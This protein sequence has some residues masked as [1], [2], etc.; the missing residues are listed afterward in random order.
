MSSRAWTGAEPLPERQ[1]WL[2]EAS[3]GTGKTFTIAGLVVRLVAEYGISIERILAITFTKAATA[4]LRDRVRK[5][6]VEALHV[7]RSPGSPASADPF[8]AHL[9]QL[10]EP[11]R[12]VMVQRLDLALRGFDL[13]G[14]L[15]IHGFCQR[16]LTELAFDAGQD[17]E[18][19]LLSEPHEILEQL[20]DDE[21]ARF[22]AS[23]SVPEVRLMQC[24]G[25]TRA[26][27][28]D[29]ARVMCTAV[30]PSVVPSVVP[31]VEFRRDDPPDD[32]RDEHQK[33]KSGSSTDTR[34]AQVRAYL[35]DLSAVQAL[36]V[37]DEARH[38]LERL[39]ALAQCFD[40]SRFLP[41]RVVHVRQWLL[42]GGAPLH[43]TSDE[44]TRRK[45]LQAV[46]AS[47]LQAAF[48][49]KQDRAHPPRKKATTTS[50]SAASF[51][52]DVDALM[53]E[54]FWP[55]VVALDHFIDRA[56]QF[57][58]EFSPLA[59]F[60]AHIRAR[61]E[62]EVRRRRVMTFDA[63]LSRL[64]ERIASEGG[65]MS[66][67]ARRI[68]E[69][70]DVALVDEFQ[71]TDLAQW[72]V[73]ENTF[74]GHRRLFLIGDPKQSIYAFRGADVHVYAQ[75]ARVLPMDARRTM[76]KNFRSD[77]AVLAAM[78]ALWREG[79]GAF[80]DDSF[81]YVD[82]VAAQA[83]H[84][85]LQVDERGRAGLELRW[86]DARLWGGAP[87]APVRKKQ[88]ADLAK[89]AA[90][91][92][93]TWLH[94]PQP[95]T[96]SS[97][98]AHPRLS[99]VPR[100]PGEV[101][102]LVNDHR[103]AARVALAL[104]AVGVPAVRAARAS[105]FATPVARW[106]SLWLDAVAC[107]GRDR[108]ARAAV[109]T[110][111]FGWT[112]AELAWALAFAESGDEDVGQIEHVLSEAGVRVAKNAWELWTTRLH[113]AA[114]SWPRKGFARIFDSEASH[115]E[116]L[117]RVLA[118]PD[119]ERHA[120]DLRH[121]FE[122]LHARERATRATPAALAAWV[123]AEV[124][125]EDDE[126]LQRLE[127][128]ADA[129]R[130]ETIHAS[131]GLE[132]P[133]VLLPFAGEVRLSQTVKGPVVVRGPQ[134][135][136]V[137]LS[138]SDTPARDQATALAWAET[139]REEL[140]KLYVAL[141]RA[142]HRTVVWHGPLGRG[143]ETVKNTALGR[144]LFRPVEISGHR[145][146]SLPVFR[147]RDADK[148]AAAWQAVQARLDDLAQRSAGG[149]SWSPCE[150]LA[151]LPVLSSGE[152]EHTTTAAV[153]PSFPVARWSKERTSLHGSFVTTSYSG[154]AARSGVSTVA[155]GDGTAPLF[156]SVRTQT[157][158][159]LPLTAAE[160][161]AQVLTRED[162]VGTGLDE[163]PVEPALAEPPALL[164]RYAA[165]DVPPR[166]REGRGTAYGTFFHEVLEHLDFETQRARDGRGLYELVDACAERA[167][168][169]I[170]S[171]AVTELATLL[172]SIL[173]T[174]LDTPV[175]DDPLCGL[176][177]GFA[178]DK[179]GMRDRVDELRFD[180]RLGAGVGIPPEPSTDEQQSDTPAV[181][182]DCVD[183]A[184]IRRALEAAWSAPASAVNPVRAWLLHHLR[185]GAD[186]QPLLTQVRGILTGSID[187]VFRVSGRDAFDVVHD[188]RYFVVDY[189]TNK[190]ESSQAGHYASPWLSWKMAT[191]GYPLQALLYTVALHRHLRLRLGSRYDYDRHM[192]GTLYLFVRGMAG[193][194]T[195]RDEQTGRC[196]GVFAHRFTRETIDCMDAALSAGH[197]S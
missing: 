112:A 182:T 191:T 98:P 22:L 196:L 103:Q 87:G 122:L 10:S 17:P 82:V 148:N 94:D 24:A 53:R 57:W 79:S 35:A 81:D 46:R 42:D 175:L 118:L 8:L 169:P 6:L 144:L 158:G 125:V 106:L 74:L 78:N 13:A 135:S 136:R 161:A 33:P 166:L 61:F 186:Q 149:F 41:Q 140:R 92:V 44:Q 23:A 70:Y 180:L 95:A 105:V 30:A 104:R 68:R 146:E 64:A 99:S 184:G 126:R 102:V 3:A 71:D 72:T 11:P 86:V 189:K 109:V 5:R 150:A 67:V 7:L 76:K 154:L 131:K 75:A 181:Q 20:V 156:A 133:F 183:P 50:P 56:T 4:E 49:K 51:P 179:I 34:R 9:W 32:L 52:I 185:R 89:L 141:T 176:P 174:P 37:G 36:F 188:E 40:Q 190:I 162:V 54:P 100:S 173:Q 43:S 138:P 172:P 187:L 127:S 62:T 152:V 129:V 121:L 1:A 147:D 117:P 163:A 19:E 123:R 171:R 101:A 130:V 137:D 177:P 153:T 159:T 31:S 143:G 142:K 195:P 114:T 91:Q 120:T 134:G 194:K 80:D 160:L 18:T 155:G 45:A 63:M 58:R 97:E 96:P 132:Y 111:L 164:L 48:Q 21:L 88:S 178:L 165:H 28:L 157:A 107:A 128:D 110:P 38:A 93:A 167:G 47:G 145:D 12:A 108:E 85:N 139:R 170:E 29:V 73:V 59:D 25:Y 77:P 115:H 69:R 116:I 90:A 2:L 197:R 119:G 84:K 27:L 55:A 66:P 65:P 124:D 15:T 151:P 192:G 39:L 60:A 113:R 193:P 168:Q 26:S 14:I 16:M 83:T